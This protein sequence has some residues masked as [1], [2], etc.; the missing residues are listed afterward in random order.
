MTSTF[1]KERVLRASIGDLFDFGELFSL[2]THNRLKLNGIETIGDLVQYS[3]E[4]LLN[5]NQLGLKG[6]DE[7][8][9]TLERMNLKL[10]NNNK[11]KV[12]LIEEVKYNEQPWYIIRVDG[13]YI[14]GTGNKIVAENMYNEIVANPNIVKTGVNILKSEQINVSLPETN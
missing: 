9:K 12:E 4:E 11:M 5:I 8:E 7:I 6:I 3:Y 10:K 14:K 1:D 2:R 13:Q